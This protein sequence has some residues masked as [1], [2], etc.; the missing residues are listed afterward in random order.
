MLRTGIATN[1]GSS[2][3]YTAQGIAAFALILILNL[4]F[5]RLKIKL[6]ITAAQLFSIY[7]S[8][9]AIGTA[10]AS[11][12][13]HHTIWL[14]L[15][16]LALVDRNKWSPYVDDTSEWLIPKSMKAV[17]SAYMGM[18]KIPWDEWVKPLIT[19]WLFFSVI[20]L[21]IVCIGVLLRRRWT[22]QEKLTYPL[23]YPLLSVVD[24]NGMPDKSLWLGKGIWIGI[25]IA[26]IVR[27]LSIINKYIPAIP[28]FPP[29][30]PTPAVKDALATIPAIQA[31]ISMLTM[32]YT[33]GSLYIGISYLINQ[34]VLFSMVIFSIFSYV[35]S[36]FW[37]I[38]G[39]LGTAPF[40][41]EGHW[42]MEIGATVAFAIMLLYYARKELLH[43]FKMAIKG[44]KWENE[45]MPLRLAFL[46]AVLGFIAIL[47]FMVTLLKIHISVAL[48]W[49]IIFYSG[50]IV[51]GRLRSEAGL[52]TQG[53]HLGRYTRGFLIPTF[54]AERMGIDSIKGLGFLR[55]FEHEI[56]IGSNIGGLLE[57]YKI[58]DSKGI[59]RRTVTKIV[60]FSMILGWGIVLVRYVQF[61]SQGSGIGAAG[62]WVTGYGNEMLTQPIEAA[63][64]GS[65]KATSAYFYMFLGSGIFTMI[66]SYLTT[67]F[68]WWPLHP[69]GFIFAQSGN[70]TL[71]MMSGVFIAWFVKAIIMRYGGSKL[72]KKGLPIA[73][74]LILGDLFFG[75]VNFMIQSTLL[76]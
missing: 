54:G 13:Y 5:Y 58:G 46:G 8:L 10:I 52:P 62:W 76:K 11:A 9:W 18:G 57:G 49:L 34:G 1:T 50:F 31:G 21:T 3:A 6:R 26:A 56:R 24:N 74:G 51:A 69:I 30:L 20:S 43:L 60:L 47:V 28:A 66:L 12:S 4:I 17:Y 42:T 45:G 41:R 2:T 36:A 23:T 64:A 19:W 44:E 25:L 32:Q 73:Y 16:R 37:K 67:R 29:Y 72:Y 15:Q 27:V 55:V 61:M 71:Y 59:S 7:L 53:L 39:A 22:E 33:F 48:S 75:L 38:S 63:E 65:P 14:T 40:T 70:L 35:I 68:V